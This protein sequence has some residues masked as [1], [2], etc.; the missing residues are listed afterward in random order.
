[1]Y[2]ENVLQKTFFI[3]HAITRHECYLLNTF[4]NK[5]YAGFNAVFTDGLRYM[6]WIVDVEKNMKFGS[7]PQNLPFG[8]TR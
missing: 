7:Y 2:L 6:H 4:T 3:Y 1:M 5:I 8:F